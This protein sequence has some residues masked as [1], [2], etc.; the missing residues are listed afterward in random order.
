MKLTFP[1]FTVLAAISYALFAVF[2]VAVWYTLLFVGVPK[3]ANAWSTAQEL[4]RL[5]PGGQ[6]MQ[7]HAAATLL[8]IAFALLLLLKPVL[9]PKAYLGATIVSVAFAAAAW[10]VFNSETA[11]LPTVSALAMALGWVRIERRPK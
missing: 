8:A 11:V 3:G 1:R 7:A 10:L 9:S 6:L 4:L 5:E 2:G